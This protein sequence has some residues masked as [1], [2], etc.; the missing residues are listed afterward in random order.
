MADRR[1]DSCRF[2]V[3]LCSMPLRR[4]LSTAAV[5]YGPLL[6]SRVQRAL[7]AAEGL[8]LRQPPHRSGRSRARTQTDTAAPPATL[9]FVPGHRPELFDTALRGQSD[10]VCLELEDGVPRAFKEE[11]ARH[12]AAAAATL[13]CKPSPRR[14]AVR[15][16]STRGDRGAD[17]LATILHACDSSVPATARGRD[18]SVV[19]R[20][21]RLPLEIVVPK[22]ARAADV[23][24]VADAVEAAGFEEYTLHPLIETARGLENV[25]RIARALH[26]PPRLGENHDDD[27]GDDGNHSESESGNDAAAVAGGCVGGQVGSLIFGGV[28]LSKELGCL[29]AWE[30]LLYARSRVVHAAAAAGVG[31]MDV[32]LLAV[33]ARGED[34]ATAAAIEMELRR[35]TVRAAMFVVRYA[36]S[37]AGDS[38]RA[39]WR[40]LAW[41]QVLETASQPASRASLAR[42]DND[43]DS[44]HRN[45]R[46]VV[47]C[48]FA[49]FVSG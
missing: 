37:S 36:A 16:N 38:S 33:A 8:L 45:H 34:P 17:D 11:A 23:R 20:R 35:S 10:V 44:S 1:H 43:R 49:V 9:L 27:D 2:L 39:P 21:R 32:P 41:W 5:E 14:V 46:Q 29:N 26:P 12:V 15:I 19:V 18:A 4:C 28:D 40:D 7:N 25:F 42:L 24:A 48:I 13:G 6:L 22:V 31:S 3:T 30:P 47:H